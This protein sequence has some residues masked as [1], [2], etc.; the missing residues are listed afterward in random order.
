MT[1]L[2]Q[3]FTE[4][5]FFA[6]RF[7]NRVCFPLAALPLTKE[8]RQLDYNIKL[9]RKAAEEMMIIRE[10]EIVA[11]N[12]QKPMTILESRLG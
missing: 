7:W 4:L 12:V 11:S 3:T 5:R 1:A 8:S 9:L 10:E 2:N 6:S